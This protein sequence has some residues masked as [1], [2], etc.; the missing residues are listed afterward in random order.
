MS[1]N[2]KIYDLPM[3]GGLDLLLKAW[4]IL[5]THGFDVTIGPFH[6]YI[7]FSMILIGLLIM[8]LGITA[9]HLIFEWGFE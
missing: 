6:N 5:S 9:L 8:E 1:L 7:T 2:L 4:E 3:E